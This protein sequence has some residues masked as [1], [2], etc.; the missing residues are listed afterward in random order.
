[1]SGTSAA[2]VAAAAEQKWS[3]RNGPGKLREGLESTEEGEMR[4][5]L[6]REQLNVRLRSLEEKA[7]ADGK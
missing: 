1:M 4:Q 6:R 3:E 2:S 5:D 7:M